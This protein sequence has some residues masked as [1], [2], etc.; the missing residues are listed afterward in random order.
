M[1]DK[2]SMN[3]VKSI[4]N[5]A[6]LIGNGRIIDEQ[7]GSSYDKNFDRLGMFSI[8]YI[9]LGVDKGMEVVGGFEYVIYLY[10]LIFRM[11]VQA[12]T[13]PNRNS[14]VKQCLAVKDFTN[15]LNSDLR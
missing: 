9:L 3:D 11:F 13:T 12:M 10:F 15:R 14:S 5:I 6:S 4:T 7:V 2:H 8:W 1:P